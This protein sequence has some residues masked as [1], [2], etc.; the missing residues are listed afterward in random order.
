MILAT[1]STMLPF[2]SLLI[3]PFWVSLVHAGIRSS[4]NNSTID[5]ANDRLS[6]TISKGTGYVAKLSLDAQ[7]LIGNGRGPYLD[8]HLPSGFW[9]PGK[10]ASYQL[11]KGTDGDGKAYAG[12][13]MSQGYQSTGIFFEQYW[14]LRDDETGMHVFSR[15]KYSNSSTPSGGDLGEF[16]QLFRPSDSVW[17]HLSSSD[18]MFAPLPNT[19]G[20]P[21]VQDASWFVGGNKND[22]YVKQMSDYFTK[23]MFSEE[24]RDQT[25]HGMFGDGTKSSDGT[26]YGA[27]LLMNTKDTYFNGPTHSDLTVDGIVYNY[28]V[29]NH[30]G[31]GVPELL[32]GFDHTFGPVGFNHRTRDDFQLMDIL[33]SL[34]LQQGHQ[35]Y[36]ASSLTQRC[37]EGRFYQLDKLLRR[38]SSTCPK[39]GNFSQPWYLQSDRS[40]AKRRISRSCCS[41]SRWS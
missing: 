37:E 41:G 17:T 36:R 26:S 11:F 12:A 22:P 8:G 6:F 25:V 14:F 29:S 30:H 24:W 10:G 35:R 38:Y 1:A 3:L 5:I 39:S 4:E 16:R 28:M 20:A 13:M 23:Y 2:K 9:T 33:A 32:D 27:W 21:V 34:L 19:T 31:N 40:S 7:N 15:A 18:E